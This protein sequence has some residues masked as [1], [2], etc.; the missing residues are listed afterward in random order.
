M[1]YLTKSLPIALATSFVCLIGL[2]K[3]RENLYNIYNKK[4]MGI[5]EFIFE[6]IIK[7]N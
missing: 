3:H 6:K 2:N 1:F 4:E 5:R 7:G